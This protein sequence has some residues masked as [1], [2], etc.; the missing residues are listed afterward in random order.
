MIFSQYLDPKE[1]DTLIRDG[2]STSEFT[3]NYLP[4]GLLALMNTSTRYLPKPMS[5][6][7]K[8]GSSRSTK[9]CHRF[10]RFTR[11]SRKSNY[12]KYKSFRFT[13]G[14]ARQSQICN[15]FKQRSMFVAVVPL[16]LT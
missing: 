9:F 3:K 2:G 11:Y 6:F 14:K 16:M 5:K 1:M 13:G 15:S 10:L 12:N 8:R 4:L 7:S